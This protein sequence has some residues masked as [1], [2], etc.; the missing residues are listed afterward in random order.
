MKRIRTFWFFLLVACMCGS[1]FADPTGRVR[2][3][4]KDPEGKPLEKVEIVLEAKGEV[5]QTYKTSTNA[6]GEYIHIGIKPGL[7]RITA[8]KDGYLPVNYAYVETRIS[9]SDRPE[10]VDFVLRQKPQANATSQ[11]STAPHPQQDADAQAGMSLLNAGKAEEAIASF[12]K[13]I[14]ANPTNA[15]LHHNLGVAYEKKGDAENARTHYQ[16]AIKIKPD[17]GQ[18]Y[19]A[20]GNSYFSEKKYEEAIEALKKATELLPQSYEA[21]YNL[22]ASYMDTQKSAEAEVAFRKAAEILPKEPI[23]HYQLG[24]A[25]YGQSK[26]AEAKTEFQ[27]YL[28]LSPNAADK[29]EVEQL[30]QTL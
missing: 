23:A 26:N 6:K 20:L 13:A 8:S 19:L 10:Q 27:K 17:F 2:G 11:P 28:E 5:P 7:Y 12:T 22:G 24:M 9:A 4:V 1:A 29:E 18:A 30:I 25:L 16:E 15:T 3:K 14:A 21:Y